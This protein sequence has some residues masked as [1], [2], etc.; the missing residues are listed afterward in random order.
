MDYEAWYREHGLLDRVREL[1]G[2]D[3]NHTVCGLFG[4]DN[5][6]EGISYWCGIDDK[7]CD[8]IADGWKPKR[9]YL[10]GE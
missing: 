10:G 6:T 7:M 8:D 1:S 9:I 3:V 4:W 5:T 2:G